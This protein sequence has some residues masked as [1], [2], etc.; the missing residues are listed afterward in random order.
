[1]L[2]NLAILQREFLGNTLQ[3]YLVFAGISLGGILLLHI[4]KRIIIRRIKSFAQKTQ[5]TIDDFILE[6]SEKTLIPLA[7]FGVV[8]F[9]IKQLTL[10]P[11]I[12]RLLDSLGIVILTIQASRLALALSIYFIQSMW[13]K[14]ESAETVRKSKS[15]FTVIKVVVWGLAV[16]FILDNLGFN[17]S[18]VIAGL[19]IGGVAVALAAQTILGDLFNY[20]VIFFDK[21]FE[22]GDFIIIDQY[23]GVIE[24]IGIKTTRVRSLSGEQ[25]VFSNSDLTSSRIRNYKRMQKRRVL[26]KV[27]VTY[28]TSLEKLKKIQGIIKGIIQNIEDTVFDRAHFQS[29]GDFSLNIEV[30]YYVLSSD[31]NKYMD[32]QQRINFGIKEAFE[33]EGIDFAYPTQTLYLNK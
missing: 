28:Q 32:V 17:V 4:F 27:G 23:L 24:H 3:S 11:T 25:L 15:I 22:E 21:P 18:A 7:Y 10:S 29:F 33:K 1:M 31:Y 8:Y 6:V 20:F 14:K 2:D 30:V 9:A 19:G 16:V 13:L 12:E 5:T 26:F